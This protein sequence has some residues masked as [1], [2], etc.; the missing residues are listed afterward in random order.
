MRWEH[1]A[2][3]GYSVTEEL[4][5]DM[6]G[7][8]MPEIETRKNAIWRINQKFGLRISELSLYEDVTGGIASELRARINTVKNLTNLPEDPELYDGVQDDPD[9]VPVPHEVECSL[10]LWMVV[11]DWH[12]MLKPGNN[13]AYRRAWVVVRACDW[14]Q[15]Q[16]LRVY[17]EDEWDLDVRE[18]KQH[19]ATVL[20]HPVSDAWVSQLDGGGID[21]EV[22]SVFVK[23][24][25]FKIR[26]RA[27][28]LAMKI[29]AWLFPPSEA[30]FRPRIA[31][32]DVSKTPSVLWVGK[33][34]RVLFNADLDYVSAL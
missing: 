19:L 21:Q 24:A 27:A 5:K 17:T 13:D 8:E 33:Q 2:F 26:L 1:L 14:D 25:R 10:M 4:D 15:V 6:I 31:F 18:L 29:F 12:A 22:D 32:K 16:M 30:P 9:N 23:Q 28:R 7:A 20:G 34:S 3:W 11:E